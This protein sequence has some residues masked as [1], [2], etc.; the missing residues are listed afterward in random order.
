M[1]PHTRTC[2]AYI[3]GSIISGKR[4]F[5]LYDYARA[6]HIDMSS[7]PYSRCLKQCGGG[8][9]LALSD[10]PRGGRYRYTCGGGH[11]FDI[12]VHGT[13]FIGYV[14]KG[15]SHFVGNV[16]GDAIYLYDHRESAHFNYRIIR[17]AVEDDACSSVRIHCNVSDTGRM[18][19]TG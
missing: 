11:F 14:S 18:Y 1:Q 12:A 19:E 6:V 8:R 13:T 3:A 17:H 9:I 15:S 7:L 16:R 10:S 5:I 4:Q 2:L